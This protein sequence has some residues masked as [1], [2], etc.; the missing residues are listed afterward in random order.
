MSKLGELSNF[1]IDTYFHGNRRYGGCFSKD[2]VRD[3]REGKF[4]I[5]NLD[6]KSG[7][8]THWCLFST[9]NPKF[10]LW[11]DSYGEPMPEQ[12]LAWTQKHRGGN[13]IYNTR[14]LQSLNSSA[15]GYF[16]LYVA[17]HLLKGFSL[18]DILACFSDKTREN[19]AILAKY[20]AHKRFLSK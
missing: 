19:E 5:L 20:F 10:A 4:Y 2:Q 1:Q 14:D 17:D 3:I 8:G 13:A 9:M 18:H 12:E 16:C 6:T 15:C 11:F 7:P